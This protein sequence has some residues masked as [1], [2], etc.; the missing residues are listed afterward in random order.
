MKVAVSIP[1]AIFEAAERLAKERRIPRSQVFAEA[2]EEYVAHHRPE[3]VTEKLDA[4]YRVEESGMDEALLRAQ[5][6]V[7]DDEAW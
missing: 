4:V 2:L 7:L 5:I 3:A 1:D 6:A